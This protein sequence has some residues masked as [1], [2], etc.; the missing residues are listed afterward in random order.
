MPISG[1]DMVKLFEAQGWKVIRQKGSHITMAKGADR[2]TIPNH[3][4]LKKGTEHS[5]RK[6][7]K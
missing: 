5:I 1:K 6:K 4:E 3:R 2:A 7:L